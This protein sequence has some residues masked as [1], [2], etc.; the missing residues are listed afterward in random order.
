MKKKIHPTP[1]N[2]V[3]VIEKE[4]PTTKIERTIRLSIK[5]Q[6]FDLTF[7]EANEIAAEI[8]KATGAKNEEDQIESLKKALERSRRDRDSIRNPYESPW[9]Q[10]RPYY[11]PERPPTHTPSY[12]P[13]TIFCRQ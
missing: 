6:E 9:I 10:P 8:H 5:G 3:S 1:A 12:P 11:G 7:G 13:G 2:G 4:V